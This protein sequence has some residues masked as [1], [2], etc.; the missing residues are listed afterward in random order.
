MLETT[1]LEVVLELPLDIIR[2]ALVLRCQIHL[3]GWLVFLNKLI[4][5]GVLRAVPHI[6]R[7][8][9]TRAGFP[10][11]RQRRRLNPMPVHAGWKGPWVWRNQA[12][13]ALGYNFY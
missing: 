4:K 11:S 6:Q 3:E 1:T 13:G 5:E 10:A 12:A 2:Q 8:A 7:R 9:D